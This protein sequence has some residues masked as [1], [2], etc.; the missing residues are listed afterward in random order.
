MKGF[1]GTDVVPSGPWTVIEVG[2]GMSVA[3]GGTAMGARPMCEIWPWQRELELN[4]R[5][6][7]DVEA[8]GIRGSIV[9]TQG[10]R[11]L[12]DSNINLK[13]IRVQV[14]LFPRRRS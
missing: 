9:K 5:T 7:L 8:W 4:A 13:K 3:A 2:D 6:Q 10:R 1:R 11:S 14:K 12:K